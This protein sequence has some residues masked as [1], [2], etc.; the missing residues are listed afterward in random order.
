MPTYGNVPGFD[1]EKLSGTRPYDS[2]QKYS[3]AVRNFSEFLGGGGQ[4]ARNNLGGAVD[5]AKSKGFNASAVGDDKID[6]GDGRGAIDVVRSDGQL[7]FNN[8]PG[9]EQAQQAPSS[10]NMDAITKILRSF[11]SGGGGDVANPF[12]HLPQQDRSVTWDVPG[13]QQGLQGSNPYMDWM[14]NE[15][16]KGQGQRLQPAG[17]QQGDD[18]ANL[19]PEIEKMIQQALMRTFLGG[20]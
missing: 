17:I 10:F 3:D 19:N 11:Q 1:F 7:W 15:Q 14:K 12:A 2:P 18:P 9:Q 6:Y 16:Q 4:L 20:R 13:M 5:F 8:M